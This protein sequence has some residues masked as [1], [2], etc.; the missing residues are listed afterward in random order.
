MRRSTRTYDVVMLG[1]FAAWRLGTLQARAL[2]LARE[3]SQRGLRCAI[4]TVPWDMPR[5]RGV[6]D[7]VDGVAVHNV[8]SPWVGAAPLAVAEQVRLVDAMH[9]AVVHLF[10]PKGFG[11]LA[12]RIVSRRIPVVVD[13]DDW[14]GDGG[15]NGQG[16]YNVL[17][18]RLFDWQ[19]RSLVARADAVT[20]ASTLLARRARRLRSRVRESDVAWV[21]N[22]LS[23]S[24]IDTLESARRERRAAPRRWTVVLYSRFAEFDR[25]WLPRFVRAL[26]GSVREEREVQVVVVGNEARAA[27]VCAVGGVEL[28][29]MGYVAHMRLPAILASADVAIYPFDD[30]LVTRSKNSVKLLELMAAGCAT[31]ASDVGDVARVLRGDGI[32]ISGADPAAFASAT[33]NLL[34]CPAAIG[35]M[36]AGASQRVRREYTVP[37][38]ADRVL[39][40][41][42]ALGLV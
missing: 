19:E 38:I 27:D 30:S 11:G 21:P 17:Q 8:R 10:K 28:E 35:R 23:M 15:W 18:R 29:L 5:E 9:P 6:V 14:E 33:V 20:A 3:L 7:V 12:A 13:C 1:T 24:W 34:R 2:P 4:V 40:V 31:I 26:D 42:R 41:Y 37:V 39:N 32:L 22:G 16:S 25:D 36:S